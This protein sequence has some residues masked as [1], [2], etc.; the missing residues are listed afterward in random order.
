MVN[1]DIFKEPSN[2]YATPRKKLDGYA[3][4]SVRRP[5][6]LSLLDL[7]ESEYVMHLISNERNSNKRF[8]ALDFNG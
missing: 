8:G 2:N 1:R 4:V 5:S 3:S 6:R 7:F